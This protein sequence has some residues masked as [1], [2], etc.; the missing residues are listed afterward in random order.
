MRAGDCLDGGIR[1][2]VLKKDAHASVLVRSENAAGVWHFSGGEWL[3]DPQ[4]LAGLEAG[5]PVATSAAGCDLGVRLLDIDG[6]GVC[7]LIVG[8]PRQQAVFRWTADGHG[9]QKLPFVLPAGATIVNAKGGD[10]GCR[11]V[12]IDGD[13]RLDVVFSDPAC[14][15][16]HLFASMEE[17]WSR[18]VLSANRSQASA[19]PPL[20][21]SDG[22]NNGAWF[23]YGHIWVQNEDTGRNVLLEGKPA[24]IPIE[25]RSYASLLK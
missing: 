20:V 14:Y 19:I 15:S 11:L 16:L 2:G 9:W 25:S 21:R 23:K 6:D 5:T 4:G 8:N 22:T 17:G 7:E 3:R 13:G 10:A 12:D 24:R 1:F 18:K